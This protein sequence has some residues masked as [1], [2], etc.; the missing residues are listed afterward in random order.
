M[1]NVKV[2][3]RVR[4]ISTRELKNSRSTVIACNTDRNLI[5]LTNLK[6]SLNKAGDSRERTRKYGFDY[7]FDSTDPE[8]ENYA[9]Q[10]KIYDTLGK[11][12]LNNIFSGYNSCLLAYGQSASG[13]TY[14][15]MGT[16]NDP[17]L[18]PRLC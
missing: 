4:P 14:T 1:A 18:T 8:S 11:I 13:K 10:G 5:S 2:A 16:E 17:G 3:V 15:I 9:D 6:V 12:V 7:C